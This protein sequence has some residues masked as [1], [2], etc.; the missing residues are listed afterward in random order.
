[1]FLE[2]I[3]NFHPPAL[4]TLPIVEGRLDQNY[5]TGQR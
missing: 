4:E 1:L 2:Y 5:L 3:F